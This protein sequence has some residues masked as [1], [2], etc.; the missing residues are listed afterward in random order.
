[1]RQ[2]ENEFKELEVNIVV[3]TFEA[4]PVAQAYVRQ[5]ALNWPLLIDESRALYGA[6]GMLQGHIWDIFGLPAV[7]AY[8]KLLRQGK[9]LRSSSGDVRQ[10]GG[11]VL[12]DPQGIV[13]LHHIGRGP[14]DRPAVSLLFETIRQLPA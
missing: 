2:R 5:T 9:K 1:M 7:W 6:Y 10:L 13:R 14:A 3:V 12:I 8:A 4:G 11:D